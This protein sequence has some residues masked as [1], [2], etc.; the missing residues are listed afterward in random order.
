MTMTTT[1]TAER[2]AALAMDMTFMLPTILDNT[3]T[4]GM[5]MRMGSSMYMSSGHPTY[6]KL[7]MAMMYSMG[8][9]IHMSRAVT[10]SMKTTNSKVHKT[11]RTRTAADEEDEEV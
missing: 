1:I 8:V 6:N 7:S 9:H 3:R 10:K 4:F 2:T 11:K 5:A